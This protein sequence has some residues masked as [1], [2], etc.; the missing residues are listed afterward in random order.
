VEENGSDYAIDLEADDVMEEIEETIKF[1]TKGCSCKK[2]SNHCGPGCECVGC[3]NL[4]CCATA[5]MCRVYKL[6][7]L[8]SSSNV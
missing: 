3:T 2:W 8:C 1:L 5:A 7:L 6:N 4:T